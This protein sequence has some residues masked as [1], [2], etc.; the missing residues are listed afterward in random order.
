[1]LKLVNIAAIA[2]I[3]ILT[4]WFAG[5]ALYE[6]LQPADLTFAVTS[7]P[8]ARLI[9]AAESKG[10]FK[11]NGIKVDII[12][13]GDN[14][15]QAYEALRRSEINGGIFALSEPLL[16]SAEGVPVKVVATIDYSAGADGI[17]AVSD[18]L[19]VSDLKG[20]RVAVP[21]QGFSLLLLQEALKQAG[22]AENDV[23]IVPQEP[24]G[25]ARD[26]STGRV[27]AVVIAEPYLS[28]AT[29][30]RNS[31]LLFSSKETPGLISDVIVFRDDYLSSH[32]QIVTAFLKSW[33]DLIDYLEQGEAARQEAMAITA[34]ASNTTLDNLENEFRG[35]KLL[36]FAS[37]A[38]AFTYGDEIISLYGSGERLLSFLNSTGNITTPLKLTDILEPSFIRSGLR[39]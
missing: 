28:L 10:F 32:R 1:M 16:L 5:M 11:K 38:V 6:R 9:Y 14:Y 22:L 30:R 27:D 36:N 13:A 20:R 37:N 15:V 33:F 21:V 25:A 12:D 2:V 35:I 7:W 24:L 19:S 17:V 34:I 39:E 3:T 26:F 31:H 23:V 29:S 4:L 8:A 18:I